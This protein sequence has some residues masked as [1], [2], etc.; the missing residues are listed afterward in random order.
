MQ[1]KIQMFSQFISIFAVGDI[2]MQKLILSLRLH[3][4]YLVYVRIQYFVILYDTTR[5]Y[6]IRFFISM[7]AYQPHFVEF[8]SKNLFC[9]YLI[10]NPYPP[11]CLYASPK[12]HAQYFH[13]KGITFKALG[14]RTSMDI[15][16]FVLIICSFEKSAFCFLF[17]FKI[18][19]NHNVHQ[20]YNHFLI[21]NQR[22]TF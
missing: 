22:I 7:K 18:S 10:M 4:Q 1:R 19:L 3:L 8:D 15:F 20:K 17:Y 21:S 2:L 16:D 9:C 11:A 13:L 14:N 6:L 12:L 5:F